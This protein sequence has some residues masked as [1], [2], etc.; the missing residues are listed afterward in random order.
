MRRNLGSF[1][2]LNR[3]AILLAGVILSLAVFGLTTLRT[4]AQRANTGSRPSKDQSYP[5][6]KAARMQ[7]EEQNEAESANI[8]PTV[9]ERAALPDSTQANPLIYAYDFFSDS[10]VS[11]NAQTPGTLITNVPVSGID[12]ANGEFVF[13][14]DF[15][16]ATG[17]LYGRTSF[18][19]NPGVDRIVKINPV[20][21]VI[22]PVNAANTLQPTAD[23]FEGTDFNP[24]V[25][26]LRIVGDADT[27]I[28]V[29]PNTGTIAFTDTSLSFD[30]ND[31][32]KGKN[33]NVVHIAYT[34]NTPGAT[35]TTLYGIDSGVGVK[36]LVTIGGPNGN[37]S[38]NGGLVS[39]VGPLGVNTGS[40]GGFDIQQGTGLAYAVLRVSGVS[41]LH[42][43]NLA[44]GAATPIGEVG[45]GGLNID[46]VAIAYSATGG[47]ADLAISKTDGVTTA[48]P[49][50][51]TTYTIV[52]SNAGPDPVVGATVTD[53]FPAGIT[54]A[55]WTCVAAGGAVCPAS[56]NGNI[57][58]S[59]DIP[60]GG[61]ATFTVIANIAANASGTLTNTATV[62]V[63]VGVT[64]PT[65]ANNSATDTDTLVLAANL[66]ITK[67]DGVASVNAGGTTTYTIVASN[68]GPAPVTGATVSDVLPAGVA[69]ATW[70]CVAA[71]GAACTAAGN[72]SI[73]DAAV[74]LPVGGTATYTL[75]ATIANNATGSIVNTAT[76]T[77]PA[78]VTDGTPANN[79]AT[80]TDTVNLIA[81]LAIT[82]TDGVAAVNAGGTTT[83]TIV[84][85]NAG[86]S[87]ANG[88]IFTDPAPTGLQAN[89]VSCGGATGGAACP[90]SST[91]VLMQGAGIVIP[92]LPSGGSVTFTVAYGVTA[93]SG[94]VTNTATVA[95][96]AGT[97]DST[98]AN[99]T[100]SDT[101]TV[102]PVADVS[103]SKTDG[104]TSV[105]AGGTTSYTIVVSN[106]GPS[107]A[108]GAVLTDPASA[109][110]TVT[111]VTCGGAAGGAVCPAAVVGAF[112]V[113][114]ITIATLPSGGSLTFTVAA[115]VTATTGSVSNTATI[116]APAGTTDPTPANNT[117]T[118][119]D[120]VNPRADLSITK[121]DGVST[122][123]TGG[124]T[125]YTIVVSNAGPSAANG[126]VF[127]DPAPTG[128]TANSVSCGGA[129]GGAACPATSTVALM[130][131][132][133]IVIPTLP[134][135][136]SVTFSVA[137]GVTAA[138]GNVT[139]TASIAAPAG[140]TDPN[141]SNNAASDTN[142]VQPPSFISFGSATYVDDESQSATITFT[143]T[144]DLSGSSSATFSTVAGGNAVPGAACTGS[145]DYITKTQ[146]ISFGPTEQNKTATV[147]L[148][149]DLAFE[150]DET[151]ALALSNP[152]GAG[153]GAQS[154]ATLI[155]N[156]TANQY[157]NTTPINTT[158]GGTADPYPS[159]ITVAGGT[160]NIFRVRVTLYD[161]AH[162][163]PDN[164]KVLLVSPA[165][166]KFVL[167]ADAG[168][169]T[170]TVNSPVTLTFHDLAGQVLPDSA[171]LTRGKFE[172]TTWNTPPTFFPAPAPPGPYVEPGS[173]VGAGPTLY[174]SFGGT[175]ANGDWSL[176]VRDDAGG[177]RPEAATGS[178]AGGWGLEL[179]AA[180]ASGVQVS[181]RVL[182]PD[183]RG[184]RNAQVTLLDSKG[185]ARTVTTSSFGYYTFDE[186]AAGQSIV[187][188]VNAKRYRFTSR[189]IQV[190]DNLADLDFVGIE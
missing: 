117:A 118:D 91:V 47:S 59:V 142:S 134:S 54:S 49:G 89:S 74:N 60:V 67:T 2:A 170:S 70:T 187:I 110:L 16:P 69:S 15:R 46:G 129:T 100:V 168:G 30:L 94:S 29:D 106:A 153:F 154:T 62:A 179:L 99:N 124:T 72:G 25:D 101:D 82:K 136:G 160:P 156:D 158:L 32:N 58:A 104:V 11:F 7:A 19:P 76:I 75:I 144:G 145:E 21:G 102:T 35:T 120:T 9:V 23:L 17:E 150:S 98:P 8:P 31:V 171:P 119:T 108:G 79:T 86:P 1:L 27:N 77:P 40:F 61:T 38:P 166:V 133:G 39:T 6:F 175:N 36:A 135:G 52:A 184:L 4:E 147:S 51:P 115:N 109:G 64:D 90:A 95:T 157:L 28:R 42:T 123:S 97:T 116:T 85:S 88:A 5:A 34:N 162:S 93:T 66:G 107:S 24:V 92:T 18:R 155:I 45:P 130:Q 138:N 14:L 105:N 80:D 48:A 37:P 143:R 96:P 78:G 172:P 84:V 126:A 103:V 180:T 183:G 3:K 127:T 125:T 185:V 56:G 188:N 165:G 132:A 169:P 81:N 22:T 159:V 44:T 83:Y 113:A 41:I 131:G 167:M 177:L 151:V 174:G 140:V 53:T 186:V 114:G 63:P 164:L 152:S 190:T 121:T 189:L 71:G 50:S 112:P 73:N 149:R 122:V 68:A 26:R 10:L 161:V 146:T 141:A 176:Y 20:T 139:N 87:A 12:L 181:G 33:P 55:S 148:C 163:N 178:I 57:A 137:Y 182:T 128:L 43:I 173:V 111:G 13:G 65:P